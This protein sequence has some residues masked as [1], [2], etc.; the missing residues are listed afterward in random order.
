M[1]IAECG[2]WSMKMKNV[3]KCRVCKM[4]SVENEAGVWKERSVENAGR[5][6][7]VSVQIGRAHV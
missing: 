5:H 1:R 6:R 7:G 3:E 2:L 4:R